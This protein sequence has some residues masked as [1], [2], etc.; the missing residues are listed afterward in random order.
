VKEPYRAKPRSL[1]ERATRLVEEIMGQARKPRT[2]VKNPRKRMKRMPTN[3]QLRDRIR[4]LEEENEELTDQLD[5]I[6]EIVTP[7][8]EEEDDEEETGRD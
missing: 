4:E 5:A 6:S 8:E 2:G 7:S 3:K 1:K